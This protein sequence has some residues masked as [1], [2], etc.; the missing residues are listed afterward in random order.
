MSEHNCKFAGEASC[1]CSTCEFMRKALDEMEK[2]DV[3]KEFAEAE[4]LFAEAEKEFEKSRIQ[5]P[6]HDK[7]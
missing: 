7:N 3:K 6:K 2:I 5:E 1:M 4:K